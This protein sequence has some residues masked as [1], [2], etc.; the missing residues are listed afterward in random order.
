LVDKTVRVVGWEAGS[1]IANMHCKV[2]RHWEGS[3]KG[4]LVV[5]QPS[6]PDQR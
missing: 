3:Q 2:I 1:L 6:V 5:S 4:R